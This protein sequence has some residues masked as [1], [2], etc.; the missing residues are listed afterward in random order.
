MAD[1]QRPCEN[2]PIAMIEQCLA[3]LQRLLAV[4]G[5]TGGGPPGRPLVP[6]YRYYR[7]PGF[8]VKG[9]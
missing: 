9:R 8:E 1:C 4:S 6:D 2:V 3:T 5:T 7:P